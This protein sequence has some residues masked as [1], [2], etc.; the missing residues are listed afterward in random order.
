M[1]TIRCLIF[2]MANRIRSNTFYLIFTSEAVSVVIFPL[3]PEILY[4]KSP[5]SCTELYLYLNTTLRHCFHYQK[6]S[7]RYLSNGNGLKLIEY[8]YT[9][10]HVFF[11]RS[12]IFPMD[13][14]QWKNWKTLG[15]KTNKNIRVNLY[16]ALYKND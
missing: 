5:N 16:K 9:I 4:N 12:N 13:Q 8:F 1:C 3:T 7:R 14:K 6:N 10:S 11:P 2:R 15:A